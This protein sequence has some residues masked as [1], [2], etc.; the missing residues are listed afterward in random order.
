MAGQRVVVEVPVENTGN[1]DL[2]GAEA[3]ATATGKAAR[4]IK[5]GRCGRPGQISPATTL[6]A[7]IP[8][9]AR[10]RAHGAYEVNIAI[11]STDG[12]SI[13]SQLTLRVKSKRKRPG[14]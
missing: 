4:W 14:K 6:T 9:R 2:N 5:P 1:L 13:E 8:I 3:C 12:G 7:R 10:R 11:A